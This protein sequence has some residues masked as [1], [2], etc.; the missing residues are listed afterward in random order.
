MVKNFLC[1]FFA[2]IMIIGMTA[3]VCAALP[4]NDG[5]QYVNVTEKKVEISAYNY[6]IIDIE[7]KALSGTAYYN[8]NVKITKITGSNTG[9]V[10]NWTGL[11]SSSSTLTFYDDSITADYGTYVLEF[12]ILAIR[13]GKM[14]VINETRYATK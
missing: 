9:V 12:S 5:I 3:P 14:D 11:N 1:I 4:N 8:G 13:N 10:A 6:L 7:L 2:L